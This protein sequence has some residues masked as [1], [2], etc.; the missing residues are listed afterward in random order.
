MTWKDSFSIG[1]PEIDKQHRELCDQVDNLFDACTR[2]KGADEVTKVLN[3]LEKYTVK[4]FADEEA[5]QLKIKYPKYQQ[6]KAKHT[7]FINQ[8]AKLKKEATEGGVNIAMVIKINQAI[9]DW[10]IEH[11]KNTDSDLKNYVH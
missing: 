10:L 3:F 9:S 6:H 2:G 5:F 4:H 8:V 7:D 1:I 11:I